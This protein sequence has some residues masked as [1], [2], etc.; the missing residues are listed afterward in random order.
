VELEL[1]PK[2]A[3]DEREVLDNFLDIKRKKE[4]FWGR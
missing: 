4:P 2:L 3:E 1:K